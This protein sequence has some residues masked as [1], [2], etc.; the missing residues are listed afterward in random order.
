[1]F[2][3]GF[4]L[5]ASTKI[6]FVHGENVKITASEL[7]AVWQKNGWPEDVGGFY[8]D[9]DK[10]VISIVDMN[11]ARVN[12]IKSNISNPDNVDFVKCKYSYNE[13]ETVFAQLDKQVWAT[14]KVRTLGIDLKENHIRIGVSP[15][16]VDEFRQIYS[17]L[18]GVKV[19]VYAQEPIVAV[20]NDN[21]IIIG[22]CVTVVLSL[23]VIAILFV[24]L[25]KI[26]G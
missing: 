15:D 10:Y 5:L 17:K 6:I 23:V 1:M 24:M 14:G 7:Y 3:V 11:D 9:S 22:I 18:Y 13:L 16:A 19:S 12:E 4:S 25:K 26:K 20:N 8:I 21:L 2:L